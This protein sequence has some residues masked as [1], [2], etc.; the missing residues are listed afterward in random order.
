MEIAGQQS[1]RGRS[2][3]TVLAGVAICAIAAGATTILAIWHKPEPTPA[4]RSQQIVAYY[5]HRTA[6]CPTCLQ[7]ESLAKETIY[8][9]FSKPL[10]CGTL[11]WQALDYEAPANAHY[12]KTYHFNAPCVVLVRVRDQKVVEWRNLPEV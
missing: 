4:T 7:V 9:R 3:W 5:F 12:A 8:T 11:V 10:Q 1:R 2:W 6:R